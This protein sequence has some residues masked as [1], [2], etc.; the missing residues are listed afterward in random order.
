MTCVNCHAGKAESLRVAPH[1]KEF[2]G[3]F[4][5]VMLFLFVTRFILV[6]RMQ[7]MFLHP[8]VCTIATANAAIVVAQLALGEEERPDVA[9]LH[10]PPTPVMVPR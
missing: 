5:D 10:M 4:T 7:V 6:L 1:G 3:D 8:F 2:P 9:G